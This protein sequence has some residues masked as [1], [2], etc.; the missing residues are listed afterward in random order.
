[1]G[2]I[3]ELAVLICG[4]AACLTAGVFIYQKLSEVCA[5]DS[6][7]PTFFAYFAITGMYLLS[8]VWYQWDADVMFKNVVYIWVFGP[9]VLLIYVRST[10]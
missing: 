9:I 1:M 3:L 8:G 4:S 10:K 2:V 7:I 6:A 5:Y